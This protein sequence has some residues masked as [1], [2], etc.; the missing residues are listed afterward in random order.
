M[1]PG[2]FFSDSLF[3]AVVLLIPHSHAKGPLA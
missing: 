2:L 1:F 3:Y